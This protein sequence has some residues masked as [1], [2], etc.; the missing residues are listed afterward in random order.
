MP[1]HN[2]GPYLEEAISSAL[3]QSYKNLEV[4]VVNDSSTDQSQ[5]VL[6]A[7]TDPRLKVIQATCGR[8]TKARNLAL[9]NSS[10]S[11]VKF[12][13]S[14]DILSP[15]MVE[16]QMRS[17]SDHPDSIASCEWGRFHNDDIATFQPNP[18]SV[19]RTMDSREWLI[20]SLMDARPMMQP[21]I[22][23]IPRKLLETAGPWDE[24]LTLID[25]FEFFCRLFSHS[26]SIQFCKEETLY[27]RSGIS[28]SLSSRKSRTSIESAFLS[29]SR[30]TDN[31]LAVSRKPEAQLA[32]AN[33]FQD[34]EYTYYPDHTDLR[35]KALKRIAELGGSTLTPDGPP[36]F[37][38][39]RKILGWKLARRIQR[40]Y[41]RSS[42]TT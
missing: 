28:G 18:Q 9:K 19:W 3:N 23:L 30:G 14:D 10:G 33:V 29:L 26:K 38:Q 8:A 12:F 13:D 5:D 34:F 32:C 42:S 41:E 39:L 1:C 15:T 22:F 35:Q 7:I 27:Y 17:L 36:R 37:Q 16:A 11:F 24:E 4:I 31:L 2:S 20:E 21:G 6:E 25:D 40:I